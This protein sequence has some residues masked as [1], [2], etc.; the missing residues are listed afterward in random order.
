MPGNHKILT[1]AGTDPEKLPEE[2]LN[3]VSSA[4]S[5]KLTTPEDL[6]GILSSMEIVAVDG[7]EDNNATTKLRKA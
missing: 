7:D 2:I 4:A 3:Y 1:S 5:D 6:A